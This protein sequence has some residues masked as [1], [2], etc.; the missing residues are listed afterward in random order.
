VEGE[1]EGFAWVVDDGFGK[2]KFPMGM[3]VGII[4]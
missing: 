3:K 4:A 2:Q 1:W